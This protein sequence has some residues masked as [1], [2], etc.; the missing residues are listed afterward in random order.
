MNIEQLYDSLT[1]TKDNE[2]KK[3]LEVIIN[4]KNPMLFTEELVS[5][6]K[7]DR[8]EEMMDQKEVNIKKSQNIIGLTKNIKSKPT[9]SPIFI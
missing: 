7:L 9:K 3:L 4:L 5:D 1:D 8:I 2:L 6:E